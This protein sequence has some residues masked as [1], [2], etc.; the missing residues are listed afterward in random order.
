MIDPSSAGRKVVS[1]AL[2]TAISVVPGL[3]DATLIQN[4][5]ELHHHFQ[6][7]ARD[8]PSLHMQAK[9]LMTIRA[10][11]EQLYP[12][13]PLLI[14]QMLITHSEFSSNSSLA[15]QDARLNRHKPGQADAAEALNDIRYAWTNRIG[16]FR[17]YVANRSGCSA[18][19]LIVVWQS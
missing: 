16:A 4:R 7:L 18:K 17:L 8:L 19:P 12:A 1:D 14:G 3:A 5:T 9:H 10:D 11:F 15:L 6:Q 2:D 13:S